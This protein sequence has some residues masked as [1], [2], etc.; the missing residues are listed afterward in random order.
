MDKG[1]L[2]KI[3]DKVETVGRILRDGIVREIIQED[4]IGVVAVEWPNGDTQ[5]HTTRLLRKV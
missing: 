4:A 2:I 3:G 1:I 5:V